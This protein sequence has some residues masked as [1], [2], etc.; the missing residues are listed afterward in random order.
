[1]SRNLGVKYLGRG[2]LVVSVAVLLFILA[3]WPGGIIRG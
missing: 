2:G 3:T 1:M